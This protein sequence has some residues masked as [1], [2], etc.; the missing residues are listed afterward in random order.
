QASTRTPRT[1]ADD[2][3]HAYVAALTDELPPLLALRQYY[4]GQRFIDDEFD[5][6]RREAPDIAR[7]RAHLAALRPAMRRAIFTAWEELSA[8]VADSPRA[9]VTAAWRKCIAIAD[10]LMAQAKPAV[11]EAAMSACRRSIPSVS[12]LP[13]HA[14]GAFADRLRNAA[15]ELGDGVANSLM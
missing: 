6:A 8:E 3:V 7:S 10:A 11:L 13:A 1:A 5:R 12:A 9:I 4:A 15:I 2:A 14:G